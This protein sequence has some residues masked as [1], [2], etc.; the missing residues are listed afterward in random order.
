MDLLEIHAIT[1]LMLQ[2]LF[3]M[4]QVL[5]KQQQAY[6]RHRDKE[7]L[8]PQGQYARHQAVALEQ[9]HLHMEM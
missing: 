4:D 7:A 1:G 3:V 2:T 5:A 8:Y 6:A 9:Q